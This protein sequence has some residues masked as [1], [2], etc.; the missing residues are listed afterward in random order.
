[1]LLIPTCVQKG[2]RSCLAFG[3]GSRNK[4]VRQNAGWYECLSLRSVQCCEVQ[5]IS[6][7]EIREG[8]YEIIVLYAPSLIFLSLFMLEA[9]SDLLL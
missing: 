7:K 3:P 9:W 6:G 4:V 2:N 5:V 8:T 1:M